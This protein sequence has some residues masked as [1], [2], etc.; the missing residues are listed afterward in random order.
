MAS[1]VAVFLHEGHDRGLLICTNNYFSTVGDGT[2]AP[3]S[4]QTACCRALC[5]SC[6]NSVTI[7]N[8]VNVALFLSRRCNK[9]KT[10]Y[11][12]PAMEINIPLK[13]MGFGG[14]TSI[15]GGVGEPGSGKC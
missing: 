9:K 2:L 8:Y 14:S 10:K 15:A 13:A 6:Y 11:R 5:I 12:P 3:E 4:S 7:H 1:V